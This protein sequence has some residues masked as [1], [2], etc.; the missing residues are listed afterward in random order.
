M[1]FVAHVTFCLYHVKL[2]SDWLTI[3]SISI[4][5]LKHET[6]NYNQNRS[7]SYCQRYG[8]TINQLTGLLYIQMIHFVCFRFHSTQRAPFLHRYPSMYRTYIC[9]GETDLTGLWFFAGNPL[10]CINIYAFRY[11]TRL[12][13]LNSNRFHFDLDILNLVGRHLRTEMSHVSF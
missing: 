5:F 12:V 4:Q 13:Y 1:K 8:G 9:G 11:I 6:A 7:L 3:L 10:G 2:V